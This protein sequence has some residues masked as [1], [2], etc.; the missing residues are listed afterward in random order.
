M[1]AIKKQVTIT[2]YYWTPSSVFNNFHK[3]EINFFTPVYQKEET[4]VHWACPAATTKNDSLN[5]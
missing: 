2:H 5:L 4:R 3:S 1:C